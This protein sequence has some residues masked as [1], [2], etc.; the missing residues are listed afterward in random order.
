VVIE[1]YGGGH[2]VLTDGNRQIEIWPLP[3]SHAEDM[4][5]IYLPREKIL[6]EADHVSP[7]KGQ[8]RSAPAVKELVEGIDKLNLD[9]TTVA[10]IHGDTAPMAAVRAAAQGG[11]R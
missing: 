9:V 11:A 1:S 6:I 5:V 3:T 2:H 10:G 7:R 8:V 4:Q